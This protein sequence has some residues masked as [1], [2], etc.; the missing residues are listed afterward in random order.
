[1]NINPELIRLL[2]AKCGCDVTTHRG[3]NILCSDI[4]AKTGEYIS[5]NTIKRLVG[6]INYDGRHR[7]EIMSLIASYLGFD[8]WQLLE[9]YLNQKISEF[10]SARSFLDLSSLEEGREVEIQW[11]PDRLV[12]IRHCEGKLYKVV[13]NLNSKLRPG[14]MVEL[15]EIAVGF[16]FL[17]KEVVRNGKPLGNYTAAALDGVKKITVI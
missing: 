4:K 6:I 14:D 2:N 9:S 12:V 3:A 8:S 15:S 11:E 10:N 5:I 13:K 16:P 1:M 17:A 7:T